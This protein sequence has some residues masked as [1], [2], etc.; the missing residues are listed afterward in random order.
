MPSSQP[1]LTTGLRSLRH[2][3]LRSVT[4]RGGIV[5]LAALPLV[6]GACTGQVAS[7]AP[8][9]T[10]KP[11]PTATTGPS[12]E[13][14][15][16]ASPNISQ[17]EIAWGRIWDDIPASFPR[18]AGS[19]PTQVQGEVA[20]A[21]LQVTGTAKE[22]ATWLQTE[23]PKAGLSIEGATGP[24]EDGGYVLAADG[25]TNPDC[26]V[27]VTVK[28]LGTTTIEVINYGASCAFQ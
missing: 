5:A 11:S 28:P 20:S 13:P 19:E 16:S 12:T 27:Q 23:L 1:S 8:S 6:A 15:V 14:T 24:L 10:P 9:A 21:V 25:S 17:T 26:R 18:Y 7:T 22:V 2:G 4:A 3:G